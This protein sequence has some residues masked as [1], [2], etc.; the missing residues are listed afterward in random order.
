MPRPRSRVARRTRGIDPLIPAKAEPIKSAVPLRRF[1]YHANDIAKCPRG[2]ILRPGKPIAHGH[3]F[4]VRAPRIVRVARSPRSAFRRQLFSPFSSRSCSIRPFD[5]NGQHPDGVEEASSTD[6]N[7]WS[8]GEE[9]RVRRSFR[10][11][12]GSVALSSCVGAAP[13]RDGPCSRHPLRYGPASAGN[14]APL[15][16]SLPQLR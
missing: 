15:L 14:H 9:Q 6:A 13:C 5:S 8:G 4:Y 16:A 10:H 3:F 7:G 1:R 12:R 11:R 2:K